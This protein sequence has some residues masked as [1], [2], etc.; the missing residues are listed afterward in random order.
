MMIKRTKSSPMIEVMLGR[1]RFRKAARGDGGSL[2]A[3]TEIGRS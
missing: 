3:W 2:R 1:G